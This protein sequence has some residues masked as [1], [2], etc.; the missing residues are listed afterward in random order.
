VC[1]KVRT[2]GVYLGLYNGKGDGFTSTG[3]IRG[4]FWDSTTGFLLRKIGGVVGVLDEVC[5]PPPPKKLR[6]EKIGLKE[7]SPELERVEVCE[8]QAIIGRVTQALSPH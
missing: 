6:L 5:S 8:L 2:W 3:K 1:L 4:G 7:K